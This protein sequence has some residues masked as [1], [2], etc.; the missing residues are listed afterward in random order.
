[1]KPTI[2]YVSGAPGS[3]KTTLAKILSEQL[4][5]HHISSDLIKGGLR[6]T[7][8]DC[9]IGTAIHTAFVPVMVAHA[10]QGV[11]FVVDHVLQKD[12]AKSTIIDVLAQHANIIYIH[13]Q[14]SDPIKR[15]IDRTTTSQLPDIIDRRGLLIERARHHLDNLEQT[16]H[17]IELG[18]PTIVVDTNEGYV[19][20][21]DDIVTFIHQHS[22]VN[23]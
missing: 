6:F 22:H 21:I 9:D 17:P 16:A 20:V 11:S 3:G 7:D 13:V 14:T 12:I 1:M 23:Q 2:I 5:I 19:P 8:P 18:I 15:Y 4:Y 10:K